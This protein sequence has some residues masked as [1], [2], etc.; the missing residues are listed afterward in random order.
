MC[1]K[2]FSKRAN[3]LFTCGILKRVF[4]IFLVKR[5]GYDFLLFCRLVLVAVC[6]FLEIYMNFMLFRMF[7]MYF[8]DF[9]ANFCDFLNF[10]LFY[11]LKWV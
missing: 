1:E 10:V 4:F 8:A 11:C 7:F 2:I 9:W 6:R 3:F 5:F